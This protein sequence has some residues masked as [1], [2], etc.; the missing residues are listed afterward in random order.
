MTSREF[1]KLI[2]EGIHLVDFY[3]TWCGPCKMLSPVLDELKD[4]IDIVKIDVDQE[5]E[6]ASEY[7]IMSIP[8]LLYVKDGKVVESN[9]GFDTKEN[10]LE[11]INKLK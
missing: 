6:I 11:R 9:L 1:H 5:P 3:A 4:E 7:G 10:I 2:E 8:T